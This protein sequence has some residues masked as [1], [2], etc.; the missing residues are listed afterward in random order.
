MAL[1]VVPLTTACSSPPSSRAGSRPSGDAD[2]DRPRAVRGRPGEAWRPAA[3]ARGRRCNPAEIHPGPPCAPFHRL[4][5]DGL[6]RTDP[7]ARR[8]E[9]HNGSRADDAER[10]PGPR[11][12]CRTRRAADR[13]RPLRPFAADQNDKP[14]ARPDA[15]EGVAPPSHVSPAG[16][17][18]S[19][20][21]N[22]SRP[23]SPPPIATSAPS[24]DFATTPAG[25]P[26]TFRTAPTEHIVLGETQR[27]LPPPACRSTPTPAL[28]LLRCPACRQGRRRGAVR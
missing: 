24:G 28:A 12:R 20:L 9:C 26:P 18:P 27:S 8:E 14:S 11:L 5:G 22:R 25:A 13:R 4:D 1:W 16:R 23:F 17:N 2:H 7:A 19:S 15:L 21:T 10:E 3:G 6:R